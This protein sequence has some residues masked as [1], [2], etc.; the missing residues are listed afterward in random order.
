MKVA[1]DATPLTL[2]SG[3][4]A[5][6]TSELSRALAEHF[7]EDE[8]VLVSDQAFSTPSP[9][10]ANLRRGVGPLT[11]WQRHWW[12]YGVQREMSQE[13]ADLFHGTHFAVPW[14]PLRPSVVTIHDLSPW[15]D[16][17]WHQ[18]AEFVRRRAPLLIG[19][20][21]AT[22]FLTP[23][24]AVRRQA[25][26]R[27]R[28]HPRRIVS[29]PLA[30]APHF[31]PVRG[32]ENS[33]PYFLYVGTV[34]P[35]KNVELLV[36]VWRELRRRHQVDLV[37]AG[38][39]RMDSPPLAPEPG[40]KILG[41]TAEQELPS[42][43]S[44]ALACLYPSLYEGFGLPVLEAMQC[45][46]A[47]ITSQDPAIREV[48]GGAAVEVDTRDERAWLEAM[49]TALTQPERLAIWRE[50]SLQRAK[51]FSWVRTA[52]RTREVYAEAIRRF[53]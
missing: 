46:A 3:G 24:E 14:L 6:Y 48:A 32:P 8:F 11:L 26:E 16:R 53:G 22:M 47:V 5:R 38:R 37:L 41:E 36:T 27:F 42:L 50:S 18:D 23:S 29:A 25:M 28:I 17:A 12:L 7:P 49:S 10:P 52:Q 30:A 21:V 1:I 39:R 43:Y 35:R 45:G 44:G 33:A 13:S 51:A 34:E 40:L 19:L 31:Q 9:T 20:G 4:I 2:S 15:M